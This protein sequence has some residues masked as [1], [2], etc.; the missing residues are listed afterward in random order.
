[1]GDFLISHFFL[2]NVLP[3]KN[4]NMYNWFTLIIIRVKKY[5]NI[6]HIYLESPMKAVFIESYGGQNVLQYGDQPIPEINDNEALIKVVATSVNP[7]DWKVREGY[8]GE[9]IHHEFP[10]IL[11]W[12]ISGIIENI[13][14]NVSQF[15]IGDEVYS[16]PALEKNGAYAE[17]VAI[18][19]D[20]LALK[21]TTKSFIESAAL[22]LTGIT[23][24]EAIINTVKIE[25]GQSILIHAGSGGVGSIA[26]QLAK[27]RGAYVYSTTSKSNIDMVKSLGADEVIDYENLDFRDVVSEVDAVFDTIGGTVQENSWSVIK[28]GG[29]LV[30]I[31]Q[32]PSQ[33]TAKRLN[34]NGKFIFIE[35]NASILK[36]LALLVD[37]GIVRPII[38]RE[39]SLKNI[40]DAH[41]L[42]E[43][44]R[45]KGKIVINVNAP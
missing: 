41:K 24:W 20:E 27:W 22:P 35:P 23:A 36:E 8:L 14:K 3:N 17:Y 21:P 39:F 2:K 31:T 18:K 13:G 7:V 29:I 28:T 34:I 5:I 1:M 40:A 38:G 15:N 4:I 33:E 32:Q 44:G 6:T 26:V 12:D 11:G 45:A 43:S 19:A 37:S 42:S 9:M 25:K 30:S 16:R 10:L